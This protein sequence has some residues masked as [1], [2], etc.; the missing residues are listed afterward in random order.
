[1]TGN[2]P[3]RRTDAIAAR[4]AGLRSGGG[5]E[6][7][8]AQHARGKL[9]ARER[10]H[11]LLDPES[12]Q[13]LAPHMLSRSSGRRSRTRALPERRRR[14]WL[15]LDRWAPNRP[16]IAYDVRKAIGAI[17]DRARLEPGFSERFNSRSSRPNSATSTM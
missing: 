5:Q 6:R 4:R 14:R 16:E 9:T 17:A 3:D 13:E 1:M 7:I 15:R 8:D 11:W 10:L 12:F 2:P